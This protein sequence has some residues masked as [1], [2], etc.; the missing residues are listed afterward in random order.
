MNKSNNGQI[1]SALLVLIIGGCFV[2][3]WKFILPDY[4]KN[5]QTIAQTKE[6][7]KSAK[8]KL[9][10]LKTTEKD[11]ASLGEI[12]NQLLVATPSDKDIPNLITELEALAGNCDLLLPTIGISD[13]SSPTAASGVPL[14][15]SSTSNA[16]TISISVNGTYEQITK[17]IELIEKD[18]RYMNI[19]TLSIT[20][21]E[22]DKATNKYSVAF[23]ILTYKRIDTSL[24]SATG[25]AGTANSATPTAAD[26]DADLGL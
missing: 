13:G 26:A 5:E 3:S 16:I 4:Q 12:V 11:L 10:S 22:K 2:F 18:L 14:Q 7:I 15:S 25:A 24:S 19:Q 8:K 23:S 20:R 21:D 17:M 1:F 9:D 6:E